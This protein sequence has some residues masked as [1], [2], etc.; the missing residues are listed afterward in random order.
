[1]NTNI[2]RNAHGISAQELGV[3]PA[4]QSV[5]D[6]FLDLPCHMTG[7][8]WGA[9]LDTAIEV[10]AEFGHTV[11][12]EKTPFGRFL[13]SEIDGCPGLTW[14]GAIEMS[15]DNG[16][17][18]RLADNDAFARILADDGA[19]LMDKSEANTFRLAPDGDII[20][21]KGWTYADAMDELL[22][23]QREDRIFGTRRVH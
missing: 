23:I 5:L 9:A 12:F 13:A 17:D 8:T 6:Q 4:L 22:S 3:N 15:L 14:G 16:T 11:E 1:M 10:A 2:I 20:V 7:W 19:E 18:V 21:S